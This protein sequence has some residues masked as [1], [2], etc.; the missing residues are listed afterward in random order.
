MLYGRGFSGRPF[1][2]AWIETKVAAYSTRSGLVAPLQGRGLKLPESDCDVVIKRRPF[3]GAWIE[4][5]PQQ[6]YI[7]LSMS[8]LC[9]GVD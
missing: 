9:R 3:A 4:T 2:G 8:P 1:A 5:H 6:L 7:F